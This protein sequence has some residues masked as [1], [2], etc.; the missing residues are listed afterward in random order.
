MVRYLKESDVQ[1]LLDMP[2]ALEQ[3]ELALKD[4]AEGRAID[5]ARERTHVPGGTLHIMHGA[6]PHLNVIGYKAYY[7]TAKG[8]QYHVHLY[9]TKTGKLEAM[10]EANYV[11]LVRAVWRRACSR[12]KMRQLSP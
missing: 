6:A 12:A 10:I 11:G 3:V 7:S 9:D 8:T 2:L 1:Q 4:R 5:V